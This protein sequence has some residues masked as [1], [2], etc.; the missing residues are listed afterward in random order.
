MTLRMTFVMVAILCLGYASDASAERT[1]M[2][3]TASALTTYPAQSTEEG[4]CFVLQIG[5]PA[6]LSGKVIEHA[7]L[8]LYLDVASI[9]RGGYVENTPVVQAYALNAPFQGTV[10]INQFNVAISP[11]PR[12]VLVGSGQRLVLDVTGMIRAI[13]ADSLNHHGLLIGSLTGRRDGLFSVRSD[14]FPTS[15]VAKLIILEAIR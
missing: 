1:T 2:Y 3:I 4:D 12:N 5:L 10:D 14:R 15:A 8:E 9:E 6:N 7:Y 13:R 11:L